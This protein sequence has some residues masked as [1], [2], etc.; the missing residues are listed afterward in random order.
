MTNFGANFAPEM[1]RSGHPTVRNSHRRRKN[2]P[3]G[4]KKTKKKGG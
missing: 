2:P 1:V 4:G 3:A